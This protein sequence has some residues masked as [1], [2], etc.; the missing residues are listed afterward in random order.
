M[1]KFILGVALLVTLAISFTGCRGEEIRVFNWGNYMD[2]SIFAEFRAQTGIRVRYSNFGSNEEMHTRVTGGG[3]AFDLIFPSDYMI[4]RMIREELLLPI[5][6]DNIPNIRYIDERF[7]YLP[8]DPENRYS[9]PYKWG[10]LGILYNAVMVRE[11]A[12]DIVVDSWDILWDERFAGNIFMY[13]SMRDSFTPPLKRLGYSLNTTD[14]DELTA[15]R[16]MLIQQRPLVRAFLG[17]LVKDSMIGNEAALALVFSGC[18]RFSMGH[19]SDLNYV[20]PREGS[21]IWFDSMVIPRGAR[22]QAGAEAFINFLSSPEIALRNTLYTGFT[23]TNW[24][25][26]EMLPDEIRNDP[27]FWP[28]DEVIGISEAFIHL[29]EFTAVWDRAWVEVLATR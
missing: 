13:D 15:A 24:A 6:F 28:S 11:I 1:K 4:E 25:T 8:F 18:A 23:T 12:G 20:V 26:L 16:D 21:N 14:I 17:D 19:N 9:V 10:T 27:A 22:N 3:G 29:G 7:F 5:N 2:E